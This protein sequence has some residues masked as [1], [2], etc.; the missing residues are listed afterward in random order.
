MFATH[1]DS[2]GVYLRELGKIPMLTPQEEIELSRSVAEWQA[3]ESKLGDEN[4]HLETWQKLPKFFAVLRLYRR[5]G[6]GEAERDRRE[7]T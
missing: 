3:I 6:G 4:P 7:Q 1:D 5:L 2:F